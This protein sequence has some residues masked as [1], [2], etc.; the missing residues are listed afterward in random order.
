MT[1]I[2]RP[3]LLRSALAVILLLWLAYTLLYTLHPGDTLAAV[4][5]FVPGVLAVTA[6]VT[7]DL[8]LPECFLRMARPSR[9]GLM[10][11]AASLLFMPFVW[12]SGR[13]TGW[14][15]MAALVFAPASGISQELFFRA[16]LLPVLLATFTAQPSLAVGLHALFFALW[17]VP[18]ALMVAPLGG[19]IGAVVVTFVCGL[20]W[21]AQVQRDRTVLWLMG[22]HSLLLM[23][24]SLFTW[25]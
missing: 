12:L 19:V 15:G 17:H 8:S 13:W 22:F 3:R 10:L 7:A 6:L 1:N 4:L 5:E 25:D 23:G 14:N 21:G 20:L 24:N 18:K 16:A 2:R 11:L 9:S